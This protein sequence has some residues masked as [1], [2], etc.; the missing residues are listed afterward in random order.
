MTGKEIIDLAR[1]KIGCRYLL[2]VVVPKDQPNPTTFD[3]AEFASWLVYQKTGKLYGVV[4][5]T[6]HPSK[7]D[8]YTGAWYGDVKKMG[9][10]ISVNE[11][12]KT[13]GAFVLRVGSQGRIG[14]IA[15]CAGDGG[16]VEAHSRNRGVIEDIV[17]GRNWTCGILIP[18]VEY[19]KPGGGGVGYVG[20]KIVYRYS[21]PLMESGCVGEIQEALKKRGFDPGSLAVGSKGKYGRWTEAAVLAFQADEGLVVDGEVGPQT[22]KALGVELY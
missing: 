1:T 18:W 19:D 17:N 6:K 22:A 14:H 4:D 15:A 9:I 10:E 11:A 16:T 8:A 21:K 3:C 2:G 12:A 20:P 5:G 13:E 7:A